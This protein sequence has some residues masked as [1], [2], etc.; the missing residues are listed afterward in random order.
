[1]IARSS[2]VSDWFRDAFWRAVK[3]ILSLL[4]IGVVL[5]TS[6]LAWLAETAPA[7]ALRWNATHPGA[8]FTT[9]HEKL[10]PLIEHAAT[11][12]PAGTAAAPAL[13]AELSPAVARDPL[14]ARGLRLLAQAS[15]LAGEETRARD[16][17]TAAHARSKR[18]VA[19]AYW[20]MERAFS[21]GDD[22][23]ALRYAD[24]LMRA[25]P[26]LAELVAPVLARISEDPTRADRL[27]PLFASRPP[28]R[29]NAITATA[30]AA[31]APRPM[32]K[33]LLAL[34]ATAAPPTRAE[35]ESYLS[36][37]AELK[38]H[39]L[40]YYAWLQF[41]PPERLERV[42][43][44][45]N[46]DFEDAPAASP[47]DW[48]LTQGSGVTLDRVMR[49][50]LPGNR[51]LSVTFGSGRASFNPVRQT[52]RMAPA[53]YR[54]KGVFKG[55]LTGPRGLAWRV[56]CLPAHRLI[57]E[58]KLLKGEVREWEAF[59]LMLDVPGESCSAQTVELDLAARS[60][61]EQ[62]MSGTML[63]DD[64]VL[65]RLHDGAR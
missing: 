55:R 50:D 34:Q 64:V 39:D 49:T 11:T 32:L 36:Y 10:R 24:I 1:M 22:D 58:S 44:L 21:A 57:A 65:E 33:L 54:L 52:T 19:A 8:V 5:R 29:A 2:G 6:L 40:A 41:L 7:T 37:L 18:E 45:F 12:T 15:L 60:A 25:R 46:G 59:E 48:T 56:Y 9:V 3:V 30:R 35:V 4:L 47:F 31:K 23:D 61:S 28:W 62:M 63:I 20:L 14:S 17:M 13:A 42:G 27:T 16:L 38:R 26:Q 43:Y 51:A 53:R